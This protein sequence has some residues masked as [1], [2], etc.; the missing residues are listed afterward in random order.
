M[1]LML[2]RRSP[3]SLSPL[4]LVVTLSHLSLI[5]TSAESWHVQTAS[6]CLLGTEL[7]WEDDLLLLLYGLDD[8]LFSAA[9]YICDRV[10][11]I[12]R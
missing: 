7:L 8:V 2:R 9:D 11:V 10:S 12:L 4:S 5:V 6:F 3:P 1:T